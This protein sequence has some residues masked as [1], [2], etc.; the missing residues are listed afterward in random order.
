MEK[1][2]PLTRTTTV[3]EPGITSTQRTTLQMHT[4]NAHKRTLDIQKL[5][6]KRK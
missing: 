4:Y 2:K 5:Y 3:K 6:I 1:T